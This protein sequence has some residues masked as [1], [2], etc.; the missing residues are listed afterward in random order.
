MAGLRYPD[1]T[2]RSPLSWRVFRVAQGLPG[3]G[4]P[5]LG[6]GAPGPLG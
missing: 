2:Y 5:G 3:S 4:H 6:T 1:E